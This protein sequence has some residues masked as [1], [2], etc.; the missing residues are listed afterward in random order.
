MIAESGSM[1]ETIREQLMSQ[2][3]YCSCS[4]YPVRMTA[5]EHREETFSTWPAVIYVCAVCGR[6]KKASYRPETLNTW[7]RIIVR[8]C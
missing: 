6:R 7:E 3:I 4:P 2:V 8:D 5:T 1:Q